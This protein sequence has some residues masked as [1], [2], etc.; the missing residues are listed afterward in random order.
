MQSTGGEDVEEELKSHMVVVTDACLPIAS[1]ESPVPAR[2]LINYE[3]PLKKVSFHLPFLFPC[4]SYLGVVH[5]AKVQYW[6]VTVAKRF[7]QSMQMISGCLGL[8]FCC[9]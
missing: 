6:S 2:V 7:S 1:S 4:A 5:S 3:L 8:Y 9:T